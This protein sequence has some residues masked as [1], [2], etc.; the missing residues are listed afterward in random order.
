[1]DIIKRIYSTIKK[2]ISNN[3][4]LL[5]GQMGELLFLAHYDEIRGRHSDILPL[6]DDQNIIRNTD[7]LVYSNGLCGILSGLKILEC[8]GTGY[9]F[10]FNTNSMNSLISVEIDKCMSNKNYDFIYGALGMLLCQLLISGDKELIVKSLNAINKQKENIDSMIF[11]TSYN[12]KTFETNY[13]NLGLA[14]GMAAMINILGQLNFVIKD[15]VLTK[16]LLQGL[17]HFYKQKENIDEL[18]LFPYGVSCKSKIR[19]S[20]LAWCYGDPGIGISFLNAGVYSQSNDLIEYGVEIL[21]QAQKRKDLKE[22]MVYDPFF[23]HGTSGL[24]MIFL[25]AY[26]KTGMQSFKLSAEYWLYK[27]IDFV[28]KSD[29]TKNPNGLLEGLSGVGLCLLSFDLKENL[30][31]EKLLLI[32]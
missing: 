26:K 21:D 20:R 7:T 16:S 14:H 30:P 11:F 15:K 18:S 31:W 9:V 19:K 25:N 23:C 27:T 1:M 8:L 32:N 5:N 24:A 6:I 17:H 29:I 12:R 4:G 13:C 3:S 2:N 10:D 28:E 22:N